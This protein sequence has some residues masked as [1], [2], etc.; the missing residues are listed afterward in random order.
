MVFDWFDGALKLGDGRSAVEDALI[1][2]V[3]RLGV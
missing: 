3:K 2:A 1:V